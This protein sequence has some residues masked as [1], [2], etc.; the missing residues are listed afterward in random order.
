VIESFNVIP[1]ELFSDYM[2]RL[3]KD[4]LLIR[5]DNPKKFRVGLPTAFR[6]NV[7]YNATEK[8]NIG[9]NVLLNMR[10][11]S[12]DVYRTGYVNCLNMTP[13]YGGKNFKVSMPLTFAGYEGVT[14]GAI[15]HSGPFYIGS[16]G[17]FSTMLSS[18][19]KNA[20]FYMGLTLKIKKDEYVMY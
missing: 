16:N 7:D 4:S 18:N 20:D 3:M 11:N 2:G 12:R 14:L 5:N 6:L 19:I 1:G 15:I 8:L 9:L 10:G 17:L 13:T